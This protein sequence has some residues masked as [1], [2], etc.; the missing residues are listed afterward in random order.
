MH[1]TSSKLLFGPTVPVHLLSLFLA[2]AASDAR[3]AKS[4][5]IIEDRAYASAQHMVDIENGRRMNLVCMGSGKPVVVFDAGLGNWS[6]V[7]GLIQP[8][9]AKRTTACA[10]DRAG[11]GFSD[12]SNGD[13]SSATI[14]SDLHKLLTVAGVKPPYVLVGHS[15]GGMNMRLFAS[16]YPADVAG[17]VLVDPSAHDLA[18]PKPSWL[19]PVLSPPDPGKQVAEERA[20]RCIAAAEAG[21]KR[22]TDDYTNC[23]DDRPNPRLSADV[24]AVYQRLQ[25][26]PGFW[27][28]RHK[29]EIAINDASVD[30]LRAAQRS[31]GSLP[32][33]VL[34]QSEAAGPDPAM[35][36]WVR[37][38]QKM[39]ALSSRG[40]DRIV[41]DSSHMIPLD[42]PEAVI[43]AID[44]VLDLAAGPGI[45]V[46]SD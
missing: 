37:A 13:G 23:I 18:P 35:S 33:I 12:V 19:L 22:G 21:L 29:E 4:T 8:S 45:N 30:Q 11:L 10:Y 27:K 43:K 32:L 24:D 6:Q 42:Q 5:A 39:A 9:V 28:A 26:T 2:F 16:E 7:W 36:R 3:A 17:M 44:D 31:F 1:W 25:L 46:S 34:T 14:V 20:T 15:Y 38:H 41:P 40:E